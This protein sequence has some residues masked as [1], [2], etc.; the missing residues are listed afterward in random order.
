MYNY[1]DKNIIKLPFH[2]ESFLADPV[3][4][5]SLKRHF[6]WI[7]PAAQDVICKNFIL[8]RNADGLVCP[9]LTINKFAT[10]NPEALAWYKGL[11]GYLNTSPRGNIIEGTQNNFPEFSALVPLILAGFKKTRGVQYSEWDWMHPFMKVFVDNDLLEA[12]VVG[13]NLVPEKE[14][15]IEAREYSLTVKS[16]S[17]I[18]QIKAPTKQYTVTSKAF[19]TNPVLNSLPRLRK[20]MDCQLW[21]A[22]P[23]TRVGNMILDVFNLDNMPEPLVQEKFVEPKVPEESTNDLSW[24]P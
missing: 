19:T 22:H 1:R 10:D 20:V 11:F 16:G 2:E 13:R 21:V 18:G 24:L 9:K 5:T 8:V 15:L 7:I 14:D 17:N 23:S 6:Q 4:L 12:V 3:N